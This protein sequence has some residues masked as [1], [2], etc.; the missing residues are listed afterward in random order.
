[1]VHRTD[2]GC[3]GLC[4]GCAGAVLVLAAAFTF[5]PSASFADHSLRRPC[6]NCH[7]LRSARIVP[8]SR[9]IDCELLSSDPL[10]GWG[11]DGSAC[12]EIAS[13]WYCGTRWLPGAAPGGDPV[14]CSF[15]HGQTGDIGDEIKNAATTDGSNHP[16][17]VRA[18]G[19]KTYTT[20]IQCNGCHSADLESDPADPCSKATGTTGYPNHQNLQGS[21]PSGFDTGTNRRIGLAAHLDLGTAYKYGLDVNW[22]GDLTSNGNIPMC[23]SC[24]RSGGLASTDIQSEYT[25]AGGGHNLTGVG[26][27]ALD[28][29]RLPCFDCH[30]SHASGNKALIVNG[31]DTI[32]N[33]Y[34]TTF[35]AAN[36]YPPDSPGI[37]TV[38]DGTNDRIVCAT[39]HD[40]G[41]RYD[42]TGLSDGNHNDEVTIADVVGAF[43][44]KF[45]FHANAH[46][47][48]AT[49]G[50]CLQKNGGCHQ[51][52]HKTDI[53]ACLDCHSTGI[54]PVPTNAMLLAANHVDAAF[55]HVGRVT[56]A[57]PGTNPGIKSQHNIPYD[58]TGTADMSAAANNGC[59]YCHDTRG[60]A[61]NTIVAGPGGAGATA[62]SRGGAIGNRAALGLF[63]AFCLSCHDGNGTSF[64]VG[65]STYPPPQVDIYYAD[66]GHGLTSGNY[67]DGI[68]A[69][70][71]GN[72]NA[73][74]PC[75]E[76]HMYHGS[77]AYKLLPGDALV[78]VAQVVK[79]YAYVPL[80]TGVLFP[81]GDA[82]DSRKIDYTD[83]TNPTSGGDTGFSY[84]PNGDT[85]Y[86]D[87]ISRADL[88]SGYISDYVSVWSSYSNRTSENLNGT[89]TPFGTSGDVRV[90]NRNNGWS[91]DCGNDARDAGVGSSDKKI[92]FCNACHFYDNST[93]GTRSG[94]PG[95]YGRIYTHEGEVGGT[96]CAGNDSASTRTFFK[97][98]AECHDPHGSGA[99]NSSGRTGRNLFM[100]R[101]KIKNDP[102]RT[103]TEAENS[104]F[105]T[106]VV[107]QRRGDPA[108][109]PAQ[110]LAADSYDEDQASN[111]DDLCNVC[112][113]GFRWSNLDPADDTQQHFLGKRCVTCH[114]HGEQ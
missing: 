59:L 28:G 3:P 36:N 60:M 26:N 11:W 2:R 102:T 105:W 104:N 46:D 108:G 64:T 30:D 7:S 21:N 22:N 94:T 18:D 8:S 35:Y 68:Q 1:M 55:G 39:C 74:I 77:S 6:L 43:T 23:F 106:D 86:N 41:Y 47:G 49:S 16:V 63:N 19:G 85:S 27:A 109:A 72:V 79:G 101:G 90:N 100:I 114:P 13:V 112:H 75:L 29:R 37:A 10:Y 24:H 91:L 67:D 66:F 70:G 87:R 78:G 98:C 34:Q 15:C 9:N 84:G 25:G 83:Y 56:L 96:D 107:F 17:T 50:N 65:G 12:N 31:D 14:D 20:R 61:A 82:T 42:P 92:G 51:G 71:G 53:Y 99:G 4:A 48:V 57:Y 5:W 69:S 93:D 33:P 80:T 73:N 113:S 38:F 95:T 110:G 62:G 44:P 97:D 76:C 81:I 45:P 52:P 89:W 103:E 40:N 58:G 54:T 32:V 88:R 111:G